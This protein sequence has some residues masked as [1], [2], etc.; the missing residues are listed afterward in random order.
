MHGNI[1]TGYSSYLYFC[2]IIAVYLL[3]K[4]VHVAILIFLFNILYICLK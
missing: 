2:I 4:I 3:M 1:V